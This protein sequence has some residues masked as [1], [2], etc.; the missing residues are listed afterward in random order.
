MFEGPDYPKPLEEDQFD[1][2]LAEGR[3]LKINYDYMLIIWDSFEEKYA[4][5]YVEDRAKFKEYEHFGE[6]VNSETIVAIYDL[7]S[8]ARIQS[9]I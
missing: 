2:W 9:G 8:E 7:Y 3:E 6:S 5:V 1:Q 4:P